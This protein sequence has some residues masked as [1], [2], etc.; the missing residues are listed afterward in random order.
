LKKNVKYTIKLSYNKLH[1][2]ITKTTFQTITNK[3]KHFKQFMN[4]SKKKNRRI[5]FIAVA[6]NIWLQRKMIIF[7]K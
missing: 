2:S 5:M 1:N 6:S 7:K 3:K 4:L